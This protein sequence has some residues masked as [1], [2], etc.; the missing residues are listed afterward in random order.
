[1]VEEE[2]VI[3]TNK[4]LFFG[5]CVDLRA[6]PVVVQHE[7]CQA[8]E[9][10]ENQLGAIDQ[11]APLF[12]RIE[13][14]TQNGAEWAL[15]E[16]HVAIGHARCQKAPAVVGQAG[17]GKEVMVTVDGGQWV[18]LAISRPAFLSGLQSPSVY[19]EIAGVCQ[20]LKSG[21]YGLQFIP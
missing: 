17:A 6:Q 5:C 9:E 11:I 8:V 20:A 21:G 1:M 14:W 18:H 7:T 3:D 15:A 2:T 10:A 13:K 19:F 4:L 16:N 12:R